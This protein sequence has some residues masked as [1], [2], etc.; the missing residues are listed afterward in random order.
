MKPKSK[1]K[2][3]KSRWQLLHQYYNYTGFYTFVWQGVKKALPL[4]IGIVVAIFAIDYFFDINAWL[5]RLTEILPIYGVLGFFFASETVLGLI[6][7]EMFIAWAGKL[8]QPWIYL[9]ILATLSYAGGLIS[10]WIGR[11]I[12]KIPKVHNYLEVKWEKQLKRFL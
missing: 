12:T 3:G 7:P 2:T 6:P 11:F 4:I 5:V 8:N 10:Y 1:P 9:G